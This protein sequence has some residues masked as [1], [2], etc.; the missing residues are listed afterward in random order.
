MRAGYKINPH[1]ETK[2]TIL[3]APLLQISAT[4]IRI[5]IK[6]G[7]SIRYMVPEKV[8]EEI[9]QNRYYK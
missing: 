8:R 4:E 9:E 2:P 7:K 1:F 3:D 6:E 5:L